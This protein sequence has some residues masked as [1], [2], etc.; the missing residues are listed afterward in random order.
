MPDRPDGRNNP[1][2]HIVLRTKNLTTFNMPRFP[3]EVHQIAK[4][5]SA[6]LG[7]TL[8]DYIAQ[9]VIFDVGAG[10]AGKKQQQRGGA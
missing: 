6:E 5:R 8:K 3:K 2:G 9:L 10:Q 4:I 1:D 7:L